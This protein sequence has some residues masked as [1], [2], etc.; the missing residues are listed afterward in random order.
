MA[1][2]ANLYARIEPEVKKQAEHIL[3]ELGIP[4]LKRSICSTSRSSCSEASL[5]RSNSRPDL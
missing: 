3:S 1:K 2:T 5:L 4:P